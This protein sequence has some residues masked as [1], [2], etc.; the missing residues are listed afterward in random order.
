[1]EI[2]SIE[3]A[4]VRENPL[5]WFELHG[6][7]LDKMRRTLSGRAGD[8]KANKMQLEIGE[9]IALCSERKIP[10]RIVTLKG[11]QEGSSTIAVAAIY[12]KMRAETCKACVIGDEYE[13]SVKNLVSML[14]TYSDGDA[15]G[16]GNG[17]NKPSK[18]FDH[19]SELITETANDPRAGASG[20][21]QAVLATEVAHWKETGV[22]SAKATFAALLN[23]VP[24]QAGTLII[25]E[26]TPNGTGGVYHE[27]YTGAISIADYKA[28]RIPKNWNGFFKV[29]YPWHEHPEYRSAVTDAERDE[30]MTSLQDREVELIAQ[31]L[32][33]EHLAW[34]RKILASPRFAGDEDLFEQEYPADEVRCFLLSG[35][36]AFHLNKVQIL[37][38]QAET[39]PNPEYC[40]MRWTNSEETQA[41]LQLC[42]DDDAC[43]KVFER[44]RAGCRYSLPV[45]PMTGA[46]QT[47]GLDPDNHGAGIMRV[48]YV[49]G[50]GKWHPPAL[51]ARLADCYA[52]KRER[53]GKAV[54][55][56]D[57]DV[58]EMRVAQLARVYGNCPIIPE[59]N[60]DRGLIE[61]MKRRGGL[62]IYRRK[63]FNRV[64]QKD[65]D[66]FGWKTD[67]A[68]RG[69]LLEA[70][71]RAIR[72]VG[73]FGDGIAIFD[74]PVI[75]ELETCIVKPNGRIEAMTGAHDDQVLMLAIGLV[76]QECAKTYWPPR[77]KQRWDDDPSA[78]DAESSTYA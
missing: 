30:I 19:G 35:R 49:D 78:T 11:R 24:E 65:T 44:R 57:I 67:I 25:V 61:L 36:R 58:L 47:T 10:A 52:E 12:H 38:R 14:E 6:T 66:A 23:C 32:T 62:E 21:L 20:T 39:A 42:S 69:P 29:F 43:V 73:E 16:W 70:L 41:E 50:E 40:T 4:I 22:I 34:R 51:V 9:I 1:M 8:I 15:F 74:L 55:R 48:G 56:W 76:T 60:M 28:G 63:I 68:T 2:A 26:S 18:K 75:K 13:K 3:S 31:G 59:I 5:A 37:K 7:I 64:E 54:C 71:N 77:R 33:V 72:M 27:T 46:S 17:Y 53:S 45:D